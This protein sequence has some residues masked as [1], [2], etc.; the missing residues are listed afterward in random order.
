MEL[1]CNHEGRL[2]LRCRQAIDDGEVSNC[3][4]RDIFGVQSYSMSINARYACTWN[5]H[6]VRVRIHFAFLLKNQSGRWRFSYLGGN[7]SDE[8]D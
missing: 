3:S 6:S 1:G 4:V 5:T 2:R 8:G 7:A